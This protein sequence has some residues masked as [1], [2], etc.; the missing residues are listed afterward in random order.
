MGNNKKNS[1]NTTGPIST[2]LGTKY[3]SLGEDYMKGHGIFQGGGGGGGPPPLFQK[4][5]KKKGGG[6]KIK[7]IYNF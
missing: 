3:P 7:I 1:E 5:G 6:R 4:N 2:K